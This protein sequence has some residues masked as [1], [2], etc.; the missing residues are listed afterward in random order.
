MGGLRESGSVFD[1]V[2]M[3]QYI[4]DLAIMESVSGT[5]NVPEVQYVPLNN[6]PAK[7]SDSKKIAALHA[8]FEGKPSQM[9]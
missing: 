8:E 7:Q 4:C 6:G 2:T 5:I 9:L 1:R 3:P